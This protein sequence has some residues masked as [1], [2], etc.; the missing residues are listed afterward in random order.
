MKYSHKH[1][2]SLPVL[3]ALG[4]GIVLSVLPVIGG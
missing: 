4:L 1:L 2:C 3:L